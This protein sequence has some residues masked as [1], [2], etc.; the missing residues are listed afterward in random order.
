MNIFRTF[1]VLFLTLTLTG[2][3]FLRNPVTG[4]GSVRDVLHTATGYVLEASKQAAATMELGKM[5]LEKAKETVEDLQKR[6]EQVKR[7]IEAVR[8]GKQMIE[9]GLAR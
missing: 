3:D 4:S 8:E 2:C 1:V 7:G 9:E 6:T 5:G